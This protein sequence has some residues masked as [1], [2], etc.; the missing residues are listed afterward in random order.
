[1]I[2]LEDLGDHFHVSLL[3][4]LIL[5]FQT[6][7]RGRRPELDFL[8]VFDIKELSEVS[9]WLKLIFEMILIRKKALFQAFIILMIF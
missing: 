2:H 6:D 8:P 7:S 4:G 1:M 5:K 3:F 9:L